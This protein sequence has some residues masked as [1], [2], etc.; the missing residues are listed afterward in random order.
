MV[1][2]NDPR[3]LA[4]ALLGRIGGQSTSDAKRA[5]SAE[6]G[7]HTPRTYPRCEVCEAG[8]RTCYHLKKKVTK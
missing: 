3:S 5:A 2:T 6:N 7:K 4:A 8:R 1:N